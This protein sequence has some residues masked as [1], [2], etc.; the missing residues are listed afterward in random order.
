MRKARLVVT[1]TLDEAAAL[2]TRFALDPQTARL[3]GL[4]KIQTAL[5]QAINPPTRR[6]TSPSV[7]T[8]S[9]TRA[10][11]SSPRAPD[12][13]APDDPTLDAPAVLAIIRELYQAL[14]PT[15]HYSD[16]RLAQIRQYATRFSRLTGEP[17]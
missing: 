17:A 11:A 3:S 6:P 8:E 7:L 10:T 14:P 1:F 15:V 2:L 5:E 16:P 12:L 4:Q 13:R 9:A